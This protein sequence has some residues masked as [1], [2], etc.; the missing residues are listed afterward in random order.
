MQTYVT[1]YKYTQ[2]GMASIK[3]SPDRIKKARLD[4]STPGRYP[5]DWEHRKQRWLS[6]DHPLGIHMGS[7]FGYRFSQK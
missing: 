5:E 4:P 2:Q 7:F 3:D 1:L 6:R